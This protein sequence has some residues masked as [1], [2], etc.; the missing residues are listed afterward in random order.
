M[1]KND[2]MQ[3]RNEGLAYAL[4]IAEVDGVEGL[5]REVESRR[6]T[7][8]SINVSHKE[9]EEACA[10]MR[11]M[12]F[13]TMRMCVIGILTDRWGFGAKRIGQFMDDFDE[14]CE[15]LDKG[16]IEWQG[17]RD[18]INERYGMYLD[19]RDNDKNTIIQR[20]Y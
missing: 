13:D 9:L 11:M 18:R 2:F 10:S 17:I 1:G 5:K 15:L 12:M 3:G 7:G 14:A 4:R 16:V 19:I 8:I 20:R 6:V